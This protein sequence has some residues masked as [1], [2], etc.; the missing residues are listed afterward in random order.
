MC[1]WMGRLIPVA[2][3][4]KIFHGVATRCICDVTH[5]SDGELYVLGC[6]RNSLDA[7]GWSDGIAKWCLSWHC[8]GSTMSSTRAKCIQILQYFLTNFWNILQM[9]TIGFRGTDV[10][11][12]WTCALPFRQM[13]SND[14]HCIDKTNYEIVITNLATRTRESIITLFHLSSWA[15]SLLRTSSR[16]SW[17][18]REKL[19]TNIFNTVHELNPHQ[20]IA[21]RE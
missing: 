20:T 10:T 6:V 9:V 19:A 11:S 12:T 21:F 8:R 1:G 4:S 18:K 3:S 5:L 2:M 13:I 15:S 16:W 14:R 7:C 17:S